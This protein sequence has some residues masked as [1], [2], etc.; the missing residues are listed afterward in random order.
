MEHT[1]SIRL[2]ERFDS[3]Y[4]VPHSNF[5]AVKAPG[6]YR[7]FAAEAKGA[8]IWDVDGNDYI[9]YIN[10]FGPVMLGYGDPE[11]VDALKKHLDKEATIYC[12]GFTFTEAD[13]TLAEKVI[14]YVPCAELF[15]LSLS[16]S[17]AVQA[18]V[19]LS[20]AYTKKSVVL[21]FADHYHGWFDNVV[22]GFVNMG[23]DRPLPLQTPED[24]SFTP[25]RS[26]WAINESFLLPW[27]DFEAL[28][29]TVEKYHEEIAM[30]HFE[31][32]VGNHF[33]MY[34][35]PGFL[36]KI[37]E[38]CD[39]YNIVMS[40]DEIITGFRIG[41]GGAQ[42][43]LGVT[44]DIC[45]FGKALACGA[46]MSAVTGKKEVMMCYRDEQV[47]AGGTFNGWALGVKAADTALTLLAKNDGEGYKTTALRQKE[48]TDGLKDLSKKHGVP[49][50][51]SQAPGLFHTIMGVEDTGQIF[52]DE[53]DVADYDPE[54]NKKFWCALQEEGV[55]I[56]FV[57]RWF[58]NF[59]V[60][61]E[62]VAE[63]LARVDKAL[64]NV[65]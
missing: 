37:R 60:T 24:S 36:E 40:M 57:G 31:G 29:S 44:P 63:T 38:L 47:I 45:T 21:R 53:S 12:S 25:G 52:Y 56:P 11:Y 26:P 46:P 48:L 28:E 50:S 1:N 13:I 3:V 39:K 15:K 16:G 8:H 2:T 49:F 54:L 33:T 18:A 34:P 59:A 7:L 62:D 10:S 51:I 32:I 58:V 17:E 9:D 30:I 27:N 22:G 4:A 61:A 41:L 55:L 20:R 23:E 6:G 42:E 35:K 65:K 64:K 5:R 43:Y 14:K 19:R